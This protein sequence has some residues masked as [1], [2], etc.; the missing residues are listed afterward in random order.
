M[1]PRERVRGDQDEEQEGDGDRGLDGERIG[2]K[3]QPACCFCEAATTRAE[4]G[5]DQHPQQHRA[6]VVSPDAGDL[7]DAAAW[8]SASSRPRS[9][10]RSRR[11]RRRSSGPGMRRRCSRRQ[12]V[13]SAGP[14]PSAPD[15]WPARPRAARRTGSA[16]APAP[17]RA[18]N[19]RPRPTRGLSLIAA[20]VVDILPHPASGLAPQGIG[21]FARHVG[22]VMLGEHRVGP[23]QRR[24]SSTPS[25]TTPCPS[26]NRSGSRP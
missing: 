24:A 2:L 10:R 19:V 17:A 8:S 20:P 9:A 16:R 23:E 11:S 7:V 22:L 6:F 25:A 15:R 5:E 21:D 26:R 13:P 4:Q 14:T 12:P 1:T 3:P 18:R